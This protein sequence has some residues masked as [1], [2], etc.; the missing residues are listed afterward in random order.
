MTFSNNWQATNL[1][2]ILEK[3]H[4]LKQE[5]EGIL[6]HQTC[7]PYAVVVKKVKSHLMLFWVDSKTITTHLVQSILDL[8]H[9]LDLICTYPQAILLALVWQ[10]RPKRIYTIGFGGGTVPRLLHHYFPEA[11]LEC[12]DTSEAIVNVSQ[13]FFGIQLDERLRVA[14]QDGRDYLKRQTVQYDIAII[15]AD[16]GNGYMPYH[17]V[18]QEFFELCKT[19]LSSHGVLV[20]NLFHQET[21][22]VAILKTLQQVFPEV[23]VCPLERI[24]RVAIA[25]L[26][27]ALN[28]KEIFLRAEIIQDF[29]NFSFPLIKR[30]LQLQTLDEWSKSVPFFEKIPIL[31][32][33][34]IPIGYFELETNLSK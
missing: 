34:A 12:T 3:L 24:N 16:S 29:H 1:T 28:Q 33:R 8:N 25:T 9:P 21:F 4:S 32:D 18:T 10:S 15:D 13:R 11:I 6:F 20:V 31:T 30:A 27:T 23:Y 7:D 22:N 19:R 5:P 17:L 14:I 2:N 26:S